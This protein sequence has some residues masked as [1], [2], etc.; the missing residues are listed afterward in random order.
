MTFE[1]DLVLAIHHRMIER[2]GGMHGVL[3]QGLLESAIHG[4]NQTFDAVDLYPTTIEK[5]CWMGYS[6]IQ[7]H[8][9]VDG[10]KRMGMHLLAL[11]LRMN[12]MDYRP[13]NDEV[14]SIGFAIANNEM[15]YLQLVQWVNHIVHGKGS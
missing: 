13:S 15:S 6:L 5:A 8:A 12:G 9:F 2:T 4:A 3:N 11:F 10:N 1:I 14:V 7:N